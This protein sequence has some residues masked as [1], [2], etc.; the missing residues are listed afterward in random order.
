MPKNVLVKYISNTKW[1]SVPY[2][3]LLK[4]YNLLGECHHGHTENTKSHSQ[5]K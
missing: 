1:S 4:I 5:S 2:D 3:M